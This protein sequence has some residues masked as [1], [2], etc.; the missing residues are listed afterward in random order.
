MRESTSRP[1]AVELFS[2]AGRDYRPQGQA[3]GSRARQ[4]RQPPSGSLCLS[5]YL[6]K[7]MEFMKLW[8]SRAAESGAGE[9]DTLGMGRVAHIPSGMFAP[10]RE[11]FWTQQMDNDWIRQTDFENFLAIYD[12]LL[13][14]RK[15]IEILAETITI[16]ILPTIIRFPQLMPA[17]GVSFRDNYCTMRAKSVEFLKRKHVVKT[18]DVRHGYH[19]WKGHLQLSV[20]ETSVKELLQLMDKEYKNRTENLNGGVEHVENSL[21][22]AQQILSKFHT[23]IANLGR[24]H[25]NRPGLEI[26]DEYDVQDLVRALLCIWFDDVRSEEW[27]PSYAGKCS[28]VDFLLKPQGLLIEVKKT[29]EGVTEKEIGDQLIIDIER[30]RSH[31][32]CKQLLCFVYDPEHRI[33]NPFGFQTDLSRQETGLAVEV[34]VIPKTH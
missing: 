18:I 17:D 10:P 33:T 28:R 13:D 1:R 23:F 6:Q 21:Q 34:M 15:E 14:I 25:Q 9:N 22:Q 30:Y 12:V 3:S 19:R 27:T 4:G 7:A 29:R 5:A 8:G 26:K 31:P 24:R 11:H 16:P 20:N 2:V 32:D